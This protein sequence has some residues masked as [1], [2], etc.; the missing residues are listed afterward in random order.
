[1]SRQNCSF[2]DFAKNRQD[3]LSYSTT[4]QNRFCNIYQK[5]TNPPPNADS[6]LA[7]PLSPILAPFHPQVACIH[8][9]GCPHPGAAGTIVLPHAAS[10]PLSEPMPIAHPYGGSAANGCGIP[11][12]GASACTGALH[13]AANQKRQRKSSIQKD[14]AYVGVTYFHS[15]SPGNYRRRK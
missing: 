15:Q 12:A 6:S 2:V 5:T 8:R 1:M 11:P 4:L 13:F 7:A 10:H 3:S 14:G 9:T